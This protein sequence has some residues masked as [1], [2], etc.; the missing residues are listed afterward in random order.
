MHL[1]VPAVSWRE[2]RGERP[3]ESSA[4]VWARVAEAR[5]RPARRLSED[6]AGAASGAALSS[7]SVGIGA[8][9]D[10]GDRPA[11][12]GSGSR[13]RAHERR[14]PPRRDPSA[15]PARRGRR[16]APP[17]GG[18][19]ASAQRAW[20]PPGARGGPDGGRLGGVGGD[21]GRPRG[22]GDP[23][24]HA[25]PA[26]GRRVTGFPEGFGGGGKGRASACGRGPPCSPARAS[27]T[28]SCSASRGFESP[29]MR[30]G[31]GTQWNFG[32]LWRVPVSIWPVR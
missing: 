5:G 18:G 32:P 4:D 27:P 12:V 30:L 21:R 1:T 26:G 19:A 11:G 22:R 2:L 8:D 14:A 24:P 16:G 29:W 17:A 31:S 13:R 23:V 10:E 28:P 20:L 15:L 6:G 3:A 25:G 7:L 9:G